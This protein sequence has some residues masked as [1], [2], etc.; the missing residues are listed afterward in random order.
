M[1]K[2]TV[3]TKDTGRGQSTVSRM[4]FGCFTESLKTDV[5]AKYI[6]KFR[7]ACPYIVGHPERFDYIDRIPR[8]CV[9]AEY[10]HQRDGQL[11][12]R[13][14]NGLLLLEVDGLANAVEVEAVKREASILPQTMA[15]FM[16][17]CGTSVKL[18]V[19]AT[20]PD[21]TLPRAEHDAALFHAHAYQL[22]VRY[23]APSLSYQL[24]VV[25]PRL[26]M[27]FR[28]TMDDKPYI[29]LKAMPLVLEQ[30]MSMPTDDFSLMNVDERS[31]GE[32]PLDFY[33]CGRLFDAAFHNA[34]RDLD[35]W[36]V[37]QDTAELEVCA[38]QYCCR[39]GLPEEET[40][41]RLHGMFREGDEAEQRARVRN[42]YEMHHRTGCTSGMPKK[43]E[44][45]LRLR[46]FIPR[47]YDVR[48][49]EVTGCYEYRVRR[50]I[51]FTYK[52]M[53]EADY[54]T[55]VHEA[56]VEGIEAF[57]S[58]VKSLIRSNYTPHYNPV[59]HYLTR[60][61]GTWDGRDRIGQLARM[62]P[63]KHPYWT[64]LF[65]RW[66]LSMVAHWMGYDSAHG[67]STAPILIGPQGYRKSTFCRTIL[68]PEFAAYFTDSIDFRNNVEAERHLGRFL[69]INIDE[70]DQ[71]SDK[72]F[73]YVKHLFQ[74]PVVNMRRAYSQKIE[75]VRRYASFMGT[76]NQHEILRDHTGNRRYICVEVTAP[77]RTEEPL[78]YHQLYAQ[79]MHLIASGERYWIDDTDEAHINE[80]NRQFDERSPLEE[81]L[82]TCFRMPLPGED[83]WYTSQEVLDTLRRQPGF[84]ARMDSVKLLARVLTK[85]GVER[86]RTRT[87][88]KVKLT[89]IK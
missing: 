89:K 74:K 17:S 24:T 73:A 21:G 82:S 4:D 1:F 47:R 75:A 29:N 56:A 40:V 51:R 30:P 45:A 83:E 37:G 76:S 12:F 59:E 41:Y 66:F 81:L 64:E 23:Y 72:Q 52:E 49:N 3:S 65:R 8:V 25:P 44:A 18:L 58:E 55:I 43:Q 68:P 6:N 11:A 50:S 9:A 80:V 35:G 13:A 46:E 87:E 71:L 84:N 78:D 7:E 16:G 60:E 19:R 86:D 34:L 26:D 63:T 15:A 48:Y 57:A 5:G 88:R 79:A 36:T 10:V 69:L 39:A 14:Y 31:R 61:V 27:S 85:W 32:R 77:I 2:F 62:V 42:V 70:F 67:N 20:L 53:D 38:A 54:N 22:A 33:T 28:R